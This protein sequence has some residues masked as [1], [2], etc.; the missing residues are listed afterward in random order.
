MSERTGEWPNSNVP[1]NLSAAVDKFV[2]Y[3]HGTPHLVGWSFCRLFEYV[4][5][6][7]VFP[8]LF[9]SFFLFAS[10]HLANST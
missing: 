1:L 4:F 9:F 5:T 7:L 2:I 3:V 6:I 8:G 10:Q